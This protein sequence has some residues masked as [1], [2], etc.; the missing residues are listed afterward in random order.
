MPANPALPSPPGPSLRP[1]LL[2]VSQCSQPQ[3]RDTAPRGPFLQSPVLTK[4][5]CVLPGT[6]SPWGRPTIRQTEFS[7]KRSS[8]CE[9]REK[10]GR[11]GEKERTDPAA[12]APADGREAEAGRAGAGERPGVRKTGSRAAHRLCLT[13][14]VKD[15]STRSGSASITPSASFS[16]ARAWQTRAWTEAGAAH[17]PPAQTSRATGHARRLLLGAGCADTEHRSRAWAP[18][19]PSAKGQGACGTAGHD[20]SLPVRPPRRQRHRRGCPTQRPSTAEA[21]GCPQ[22]EA[23][24]EGRRMT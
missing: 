10:G 4:D 6:D 11:C 13:R 18:Q 15:A 22:G 9:R 23:G 17:T 12:D 24:W 1:K 2:L 8:A 7:T 21:G 16:R 3:H 5:P 14:N 19:T 20:P